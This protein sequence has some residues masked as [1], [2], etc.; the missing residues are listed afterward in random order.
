MKRVYAIILI[1]I[2]ALFLW[3]FGRKLPDI[4]LNLGK[5]DYEQKNYVSAFQN[6]KTALRFS[7][8][9]KDA[10]YYFVQTLLKL[11][12]TLEIQKELCDIV[13][14]NLNDSADLI[15]DIQLAKWKEQILNSI[16][17][18]YIERAPF[19]GKIMRWDNKFPLKVY[20]KNNSSK[21]PYFEAQV[22]KAFRQWQATSNNLVRFEFVNNEKDANIE[23]VVN[24]SDEMKKCTDENCKY[25]VA[26]TEPKISGDLLEKMQIFFYDSNNLGD[27]FSEEQIYNTALHEIGHSL[28][29]MGHSQNKDDLMYM[30]GNT[31]TVFDPYRSDF[32][33]IS[34]SDIGT[35]ILLYK[36]Y[37]EI[38]NTPLDKIDKSK[39]YYPHIVLGSEEQVTSAKII[40]AQ[41]YISAAPELPNG[42]LDLAV[43]YGESKQYA[44]AVETLEKALS[45]CSNDEERFTVYYNFAVTYLNAQDWQ[46]ALKYAQLAKAENPSSEID[47]LIAMIYFKS[48][49]KEQ[50]KTTYIKSLQ[51]NPTNIIDSLNLAIIYIRDFNLVQAGKVL[52]NL[53]RVNPEAASDPR[54]KAYSLIMFFFK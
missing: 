11:R 22:Q 9:N 47:G 7:P 19:N 39:T 27:A 24:S 41:N 23:V 50:A 32:Q 48:G 1:L 18:N 30:Q 25:S 40:E 26:Y 29:I 2:T 10:R 49:N 21:M 33:A 16:G 13:Q 15:A 5:N 37:P 34:S 3:F 20:I 52:N 28:G 17:P 36:L 12:P 35:L 51:K 4:Y 54:V 6:L 43:A 53:V 14:A 38:T 42:Y 44:K 46:N 8:K 31:D 45:L